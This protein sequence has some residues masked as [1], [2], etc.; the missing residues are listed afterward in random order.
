MNLSKQNLS[1]VHS[2]GVIMPHKDTFQLP[3]KVLQFGTGVLL[4]GLPDFFIDKANNAGIFN[5]RVVI[6]KSTSSG[7]T[8]AFAEQDSLYTQL[9]RGVE[10]G[11][12]VEENRINAAVSR[13]ISAKEHWNDVLACAANPH[14]EIIISNTTEVGIVL[15]E[16]DSIHAH[17]PVSF[18]GKLL[19]FLY[20]RFQHFNGDPTKGMV[21]IPTELIIDNGKKLESIVLEL[22]HLNN[23]D[24]EFMD[25]LESSNHFCNSLVDRIVPGKLNAKQKEDIENQLGVTDDL[26]IMSESYSLW[27]IQTSDPAVAEKLSF[28]K[29]DKG[30]VI[31]KDIDKF[32]E[33]KLRLLNGT[34]TFSCGLAFLS[35]FN[36]VKE[37]ME[38]KNMSGFVEHLM[39]DEMGPAIPYPISKED[40]NNFAQQVL[41]R[42]RNPH[43]EHLWLN[44]TVQYSSKMKLRN[45][46]VLFQ[47]YKKSESVP[48]HMALGFAAHILFMNCSEQDGKFFGTAN[49]KSYQ[50]QDDNAATYAA[51]WKQF[52][53]AELVQSVLSDVALWEEDLSALPG[54]KDAVANWLGVLQQ[55]NALEVLK[56]F[57]SERQVALSI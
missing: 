25:W 33:L 14:M 15:D 27:A 35:G 29:A 47:H 44:I 9:I 36:T 42:F 1:A 21:I 11:R 22:A 45:V 56:E 30:V 41:D 31:A 24:P 49:G 39:I 23:V 7:G 52:S 2:E 40:S 37:A 43:I 48:E 38:N 18:P 4:R 55:R 3:E 32:R 57:Q 34:H 26:V 5:G 54:F 16:T 28:S 10:Q 50:V 51:K 46:P 13:V 20:K 6:V 12:K 53:G 17:P 19:A 8:D